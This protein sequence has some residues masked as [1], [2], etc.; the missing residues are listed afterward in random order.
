MTAQASLAFH[1]AVFVS[2]GLRRES[3][4]QSDAPAQGGLLP[5]LGASWV[6]DRGPVTMKLR[7]AYGKGI[8]GARSTIHVGTR[9]PKHTLFNRNLAAEE[10]A[11][12]EA[13]GDLLFGRRVGLHVTRFDQLASGLIQTVLIGD[14]YDDDTTRMGEHHSWF[15]LQNVGQIVNR[16]WEGQATVSLGAL[17]L[18]GAAALVESRVRRIAPTYTGDL[19]PGDRMFG[20]PSRTFSGTMAWSRPGGG[21]QLS[22]TISRANDWVNY[23]RLAIA[24]DLI[25]AGGDARGFT[26]ANLRKYWVIYPGATRLR[27]SAVLD[28]WRGMSL[29]LTGENLL[30]Y[31]RGE[32]DTI[33]IVPGRTVLMGLKARF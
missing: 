23:D 31:Q 20:V 11:G 2:G 30:N 29:S 28:V 14:P 4:G 7:A 12:I 32:P 17:S 10:Q 18:S 1:N 24:K 8:R 25:A 6:R 9:E 26:G 19:L 22:S 5:M 15:Q 27:A 21:L 16:G 33:T 3:I 13:G